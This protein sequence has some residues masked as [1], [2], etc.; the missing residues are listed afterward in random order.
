MSQPQHV[1]PVQATQRLEQ[2]AFVPE[3]EADDEVRPFFAHPCDNPPAPLEL[4]LHAGNAN[5]CCC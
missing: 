2:E 4:M 3:E 5:P 1:T